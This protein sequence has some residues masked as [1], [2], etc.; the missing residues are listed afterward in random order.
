M[1]P[2]DTFIDEEDDTC[3][4]CIEEF[5]LS[6]RN[7][8]PCPCGYQVC[9]FCFNNIKNNMNGLCPACRRPY[10]EKTIQW[11]VVTTEEV[12]EFRANIQKNQKKRAVEQKQK[13]VQKREV[14]KENRKNL[15]GVRV[16]QKN[17][18]YVTGLTPTVREDELLKTLRKPEFFGQ[19]GNIL[20]ISISSR[21][22]Q[23][24][25]HQSL[26]IYVTFEKK[27]D[28]Q[29]CIQAVN[30]SQNGDRV[31]RAQLGTT[32]YCSAWLRHEQCTNRQCMFLHELG[33]EE[34]SYTRQ[35]L[36]SMNSISS[37][38]PLP[39]G[40]S[41][42]SGGGP[43]RTASRQ[44]NTAPP[45]APASQPM[46]R[47][48]SK[49]GSE[50]GGDGPALPASAN[51]ARN[52]QRSRRGSHAT[53]GAA[54]SPAISTAL[55]V[56]TEAVPE[57]IDE[58]PS[59]KETPAPPTETK[60]PKPTAPADNRKSNSLPENLL[61][62]LLK[63]MQG[64]PFSYNA[65]DTNQIETIYPPMFDTRGGEKRRAM[66]EEEESR[67]G[68][69][70]EQ[71]SEPQEASEGEPETG[72]SLA[73]GGEPEDRDVARDV[74]FEQRRPGTQP[75]IQRNNNDG[76]FGPALGSGFGQASVS[77][78]S[79]GGSRSMTP[80]QQL[81]VRSQSGFGDHLPPGIPTAQPS[82]VQQQGGG[83]NRQGSRFSFANDTAGTSASVKVAANP[84][85]MAQQTAMMP[86]AFHS[87]PGSQYYA[88]SMPGPP[89]G[90]KSTGT[91]PNMFG[92]GQFG[93][94][95]GATSKD[96]AELLQTLIRGRGTNGQ[97]HDA[98]KR[99]YMLSSF[100]N[101]YPSSTSSTPAPASGLLAS[102]YGNQPG[103]FQDFGPKQKKKGK[104]HRHANTSSSGGGGLVDLADPSILQARMQHQ[105]Q[106][107]AGVGQGLFG[108]QSQDDD[109]FSLDDEATLSVDKLVSDDPL[110]SYVG[111]LGGLSR[112][113]APTPPP[114]LGPPQ[115]TASPAPRQAPIPVI[116]VTPLTP[117]APK[118]AVPTM[119]NIVRTGTPDQASRKKAGGTE[120]KKNIK[121]LAVESGLSKDIASQA[122]PSKG[123]S[124][125]Q[126]QEEDFPAL[127]NVPRPATPAKS[128]AATPKIAPA[129]IKKP[130]PAEA[131]TPASGPSPVL[132]VEAP[133]TTKAT[134]KPVPGILN[135]AAATSAAQAKQPETTTTE[136]SDASA[137]PALPTP[138]TASVASPIARA[139][140]KTL[141]VVP[142][143]KAEVPPALPSGAAFSAA[144]RAVSSA[145]GRP[146]TPAS[147]IISDSASIVSASVSASRTSSP[148]PT[149][150][151]TAPVRNTTKSQQRK[152]RKEAHKEQSASITVA[153]KV[154]ETE[155]QAPILGRKKKQK[156]EKPVTAAPTPVKKPVE[157]AATPPPPPKEP[158]PPPKPIVERTVVDLPPPKGKAAKQAAKMAKAA[159]EKGKSKEGT[160][161]MPT[162]PP[163]APTA[164]AVPE[165]SQDIADNPNTFPEVVY[166][167][168]HEAGEVPTA[169]L[170]ALLKPFLDAHSR[171][172]RPSAATLSNNPPPTA[173]TK[174]MV[175][176]ADHAILLT[177]QPVRKIMEGQRV[178]IT[179]NGDCLRNLT[180]EE[181]G[182]Y[183]ALQKS[184]AVG[185]DQP[186]SFVAPRHQARPGGFSLIKGRAVPNGPPSYFPPSPNAQKMFSDD[187][188]NKIQREE[189][190]SYINQFVL[191]RLNLGNTNLF[192]GSW[193]SAPGAKDALSARETAA[194]SLNSLAPYIYGH[195]A[196]AGA[197]IYSAESGGSGKDIPED[198]TPFGGLDSPQHQQGS[199]GFV[200]DASPSTMAAAAAQVDAQQRTGAV[201]PKLPG[202]PLNAMSLM[203]VEDA[204]SALGIARKETEKLEKG[205][206][207]AMKRNR[208]LLLGSR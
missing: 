170:L 181:E 200:T 137:F 201:H 86:S 9:Q 173:T 8:R 192:P 73:L 58:T 96:S 121:A 168:L 77:A 3:P 101:Q 74:V 43:S 125:L 14:E 194:A 32:K 208:R 161:T 135:I 33:D 60:A 22:S 122:S 131:A 64:C 1:A 92:Q 202:T 20:K 147:E 180:E 132:A 18:V 17:L 93:G 116:P 205:L 120:A 193:K 118:P 16:V 176:E 195:D 54:S 47:S 61:R 129:S 127:G 204:E 84:R 79:V 149:R 63:A 94:A 145:S 100:S 49:D 70:Q 128:A 81:F 107:N 82:A 37:Q 199:E 172:D 88:S 75:P 171:F 46:A 113:A 169:E 164:V 130:Q 108:G 23:D 144:A 57:A 111:T 148:P 133:K 203:S 76:P 90:L 36:S 48:S 139:A 188:V 106:S 98:G 21:K 31:L 207:Q 123:K 34:D 156:K 134:E 40:G 65:P 112:P 68:V 26:G 104:K 62:Q 99:E 185:S 189:A 30:G 190:I 102:L 162:P 5:D 165:E 24:G 142:T 126:L 52:P 67:L 186:D 160:P 69:E 158:T 11:K 85:I 35:D 117:S 29:R 179:P 166:H 80:Q 50:N 41:S 167:A 53:S 206:N 27:E 143:P 174:N 13:E 184:V 109:L 198:E 153:P 159:E 95:F 114:G 103:A 66:R 151:G 71:Q 154:V 91:P 150:V 136:Q 59:R 177:G 97:G 4:L 157:R 138:T 83:H 51:W 12:A 197:G 182:R 78:S 6:D 2:Q 110:P 183:L 28:A 72:G 175:S 44:Q 7:F 15:I 119:A 19:Y 140:P 187:P 155:E 163:P 87:Q 10:D 196:A 115:R 105:S 178:L 42:S 55:P 152:Q 25:Q 146:G 39:G 89:P 56:T 38:R 191:P 141:R 124:V 45:A